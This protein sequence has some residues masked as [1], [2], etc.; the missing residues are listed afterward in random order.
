MG[1]EKPEIYYNHTED[2]IN[3]THY[4]RR[5]Y[6]L[7]DSSWSRTYLETY[8]GKMWGVDLL[9][10]RL[11]ADMCKSTIEVLYNTVMDIDCRIREYDRLVKEDNDT[12]SLRKMY[13]RARSIIIDIGEYLD[14]DDLYYTSLLESCKNEGEYYYDDEW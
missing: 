3:I 2:I 12:F 13:V 11:A 6:T 9:L 8:I 10:D 5:R 4:I 7:P 1:Y 14:S